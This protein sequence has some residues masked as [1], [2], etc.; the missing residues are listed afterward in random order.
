[1]FLVTLRL[2]TKVVLTVSTLRLMTKVVINVVS[3]ELSRMPSLARENYQESQE[4][5]RMLY[6]Y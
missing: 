5:S 3:E 2:L 1:M 4:L 6:N